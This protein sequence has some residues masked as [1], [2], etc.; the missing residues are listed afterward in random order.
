MKPI[1]NITVLLS[2]GWQRERPA[3]EK[4]TLLLCNICS[5]TKEFN[6]K[7]TS[8]AFI[9]PL[10]VPFTSSAS[11]QQPPPPMRRDDD[12]MGGYLLNVCMYLC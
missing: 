6:G 4:R 7:I 3:A 5:D 11:Y 9:F 2:N 12:E 1:N 8:Q 10:L